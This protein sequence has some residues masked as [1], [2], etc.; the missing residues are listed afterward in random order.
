MGN[1]EPLKTEL[2]FTDILSR[3]LTE[4]NIKMADAGQTLANDSYAFQGT[5][6]DI[7]KPGLLLPIFPYEGTWSTAVRATLYCCGLIYCFMGVAI[8]ADIFMGSI[9]KITSKTKKVCVLCIVQEYW[10]FSI[11]Y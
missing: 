6:N 8:V 7:C 11:H 2:G 3:V 10:G 9:E 1:V 4:K 5:Y